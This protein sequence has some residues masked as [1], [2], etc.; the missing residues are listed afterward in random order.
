M[1]VGMIFECGH[2]GA[3]KKV[4]EYLA[5]KLV[6]DIEISSVTLDSK[7]KLLRDCGEKTTVLLEEG[8]EQVL[9]IWDL[10]PPWRS[11]KEKPCRKED[12]EKIFDS[13]QKAGVTSSN[14]HLVCIREELEAWLLA[15][16]RAVS[17]VLSNPTHPVKIKDEKKP[18]LIKN[19]KGKLRKI[20][21]E[22]TGKDYNDK[23]H[24]EKIVRALPN[25]KKIKRSFSFKRFVK[26]LTGDE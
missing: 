8:C 9:I 10:Y 16:G 14:I 24:A 4:C 25:F 17:T 2:E 11:H 7:P 15:D 5:Q 3:D 18:D 1:K 12:R 21:N 23:V 22:K 26:K 6:P 13:L 19:P 20:F